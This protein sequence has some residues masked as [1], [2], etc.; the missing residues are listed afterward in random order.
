[1][2]YDI[3]IKTAAWGCSHPLVRDQSRREITRLK[4]AEC[5]PALVG[6]KHWAR[7]RHSAFFPVKK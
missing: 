5:R 4:P 6:L 2:Y 1:M 7:L 3:M